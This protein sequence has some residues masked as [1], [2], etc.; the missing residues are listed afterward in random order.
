MGGR[1]VDSGAM[2]GLV[3]FDCDGVLVD[4]DRIWTRRSRS[5]SSDLGGRYLMA[6]SR[7]SMLRSAQ[8]WERSSSRWPA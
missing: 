3:I 6:G 4:S 5:S 2:D 7:S 8:R 1:R